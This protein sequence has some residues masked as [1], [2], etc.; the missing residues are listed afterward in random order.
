MSKLRITNYTRYFPP[1]EGAGGGVLRSCALTLLLFLSCS[2]LYG[3]ISTEEEKE[4]PQERNNCHNTDSHTNINC[5]VGEWQVEKDAIVRIEMPLPN[6]RCDAC[7]GT[8]VNT[9]LGE[10]NNHHYILTAGHCLVSNPINWKFYWHYEVPECYPPYSAAPEIVTTGARLV[11]IGTEN[12]PMLPGDFALLEL[13]E[14]PS[15]AW[16]VTPY[17]L[18]WD[19]AE[20]ISGYRKMIYHPDGK[21]KK[22][23]HYSYRH[24][25]AA[26]NKGN[27]IGN[28][29]CNGVF[30]YAGYRLSAGNLFVENGACGAPLLREDTKRIVG[31]LYEG[32]DCECTYPIT[33]TSCYWMNR[34]CKFS[35]AWE[36]D[37]YCRTD[38]TNRLR[39]WLDPINTGQRTLNGRS[40]CKKTIKLWHSYPQA[41]YHA[42]DTI[43][44]KQEIDSGLT[45]SY[46]AGKEIVFLD[47][48]HASSGT[49][50]TAQIEPLQCNNSKSVSDFSQSEEQNDEAYYA[51]LSPHHVQYEINLLPNPNNGTFQL[52]TNFSLSEIAH[53]KITN[54]LGTVMYET[55]NLTSTGIQLPASASGLQFVIVVLKDGSVLTQ[56]MMIQR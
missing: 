10:H 6:G 8:L 32:D 43:I 48:F 54:L 46:K 42:V 40:V 34:F 52:E 25:L 4:I 39:D 19:A 47:G 38:P 45:V 29:S 31:I 28:F 24:G 50:F 21:D 14:D 11:A 27:D 33:P 22:I 51:P 9:T 49:D 37:N 16:D 44:S 20:D 3:Q 56:K 36:D 15:K 53:L 13:L 17:Y 41:N 12:Y 5:Y 26:L 7:T 55:Q 18:G 23:L 1:L 2:M 35:Y 30:K